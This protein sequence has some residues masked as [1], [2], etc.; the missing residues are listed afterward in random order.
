[1]SL[2]C[3][4]NNNNNNK[5]ANSK[6]PHGHYKSS[7]APNTNPSKH[8]THTTH[9]TPHLYYLQGEYEQRVF[10]EL[11]RA[12]TLNVQGKARLVPMLA[13]NSHPGS[14][15]RGEAAVAVADM[16]TVAEAEVDSSPAL[17]Q[18]VLHLMQVLNTCVNLL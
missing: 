17:R 18:P 2:V 11:W 6:S 13:M 10:S 1:M 16:A 14:W 15:W 4:N 5:N 9:L 3:P 8:P 7:P 12:N